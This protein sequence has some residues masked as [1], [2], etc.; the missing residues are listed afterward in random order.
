MP[1]EMISSLR[2]RSSGVATY[3]QTFVLIAVAL[4]GSFVAYRAVSVYADSAGGAAI[5]V[6][7]AGISQ[8]PGTALERLTVSDSGQTDLPSFTVLNPG[9][10][11]G[12]SYCYA[13]TSSAGS[14]VVQTCPEMALDPTSILIPTNLTSGSTVVVLVLLQGADVVIPGKVYSFYAEAPGAAVWGGQMV[15]ETE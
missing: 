13:V 2:P 10:G 1:T 5:R 4:G 15:A 6:W 14:P 11:R 8:G 3:L 7:D 12:F 9:L